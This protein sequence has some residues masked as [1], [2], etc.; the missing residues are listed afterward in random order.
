[1]ELVSYKFTNSYIQIVLHFIHISSPLIRS[2]SGTWDAFCL[3]VTKKQDT[4]HVSINTLSARRLKQPGV[5]FPYE[6]NTFLNESL[7]FRFIE[8]NDILITT[9]FVGI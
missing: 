3:N 5:A 4:L 8:Y 2:L 1:M 7:I 6:T 9:F